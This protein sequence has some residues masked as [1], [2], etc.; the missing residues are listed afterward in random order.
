MKRIDIFERTYGAKHRSRVD[1]RRQG[2]LDQDAVDTLARIPVVVQSID[3]SEQFV[4]FCCP[5]QAM[6]LAFHSDAL[7]GKL[8]VANVNFARRIVADQHGR[9]AWRHT[10][11]S[12]KLG[13]LRGKLLL[14][15]RR[16]S[17][18]VENL[19]GHWDGLEA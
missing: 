17:F 10:A 16:Q 14:D 1:L 6:K 19:S 18:A 7:A 3:K 11:G 13:H 2:C 5:R 8:L 12:E 4:S 9:Q 15:R